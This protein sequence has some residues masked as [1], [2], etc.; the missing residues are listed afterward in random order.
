GHGILIAKAEKE[1]CQLAEKAG[2]P[3]GST[4]HGL[5]AMPD[6]HPLYVG[7]LGMHGNYGP[8]MLTNK[9]DV[10]LAVGMRFDD[11]VTGRLSDYARQAKIIHV[12]IDPAE[13]NKNVTADV[14]IVA[15]AKD[16][17]AALIGKVKKQEHPEWVKH[18]RTFDK[19]EKTKVIE[20]EIHPKEGGIT[21]AEV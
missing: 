18:F 14:P 1:V 11:R 7:M 6:D 12:D 10:I 9:A 4:L 8:N 5:S 20:R 19:E 16:A 17:L 13:L 21:M 2:I 15:D 3:V